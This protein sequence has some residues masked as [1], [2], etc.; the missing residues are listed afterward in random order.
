MTDEYEYGFE[1]RE[2]TRS[3]D[4][5]EQ[6]P[7]TR[8]VGRSY[9]RGVRAES[10][11]VKTTDARMLPQVPLRAV[12]PKKPAPDN[13]PTSRIE[14]IEIFPGVAVP[15]RGSEETQDAIING[16]YDPVDCVCCEASLYVVRD[17]G[18]IICP[19]CTVI[20]LDPMRS[21]AQCTLV[22]RE[23]DEAVLMTHRIAG[24]VGLGFDLAELEL[25]LQQGIP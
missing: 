22:D 19:S 16:Y 15:L 9:R 3:D 8:A 21:D 13:N 18:Y 6:E 17:A 5:T 11:R 7:P 14:E 20:S 24:G 1:T 23:I 12:F 4:F 10:R 2:S 25:V